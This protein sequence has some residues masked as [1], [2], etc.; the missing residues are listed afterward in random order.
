MNHIIEAKVVLTMTT[1][2]M[3]AAGNVQHLWSC[4]RPI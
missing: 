3:H 4:G 2:L 1:S